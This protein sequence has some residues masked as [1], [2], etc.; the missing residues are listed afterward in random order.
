MKP[1]FADLHLKIDLK[2][3]S[4]VEY[5]VKRM[6]FLGYKL[7]AIPLHPEIKNEDIQE[8]RNKF[9]DAGIDFASRI[10]LYPRNQHELLGQL[11]KLRRKFELIC[12][13]CQSK[14]VARQAAK[15]RRVDL[16]NFPSTYYQR[17]FFDRAEAELAK[18]GLAAMEIDINPFLL[19]QGPPRIRIFTYLRR[20]LKIAS[21][22]GLPIVI[23]SGVN[24]LIL[25]RKPKEIVALASLLDLKCSDA[26]EAVS[27]NPEEIILRNREKLEEGFVEIGRAHV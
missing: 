13:L 7:I 10:D 9:N 23:S 20:E 8:I 12:V 18:N 27:R 5:A 19:L 11:R 3:E 17:R 24:D 25:T 26:L 14:E 21:S 4:I 22:F 6:N 1:K 15:D 16:I 2:K